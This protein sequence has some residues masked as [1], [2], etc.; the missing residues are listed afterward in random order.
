MKTKLL[1]LSMAIILSL[2]VLFANHALVNASFENFLTWTE[3]DG[4]DDVTVSQYSTQWVNELRGAE[5]YVYSD[6]GVGYLD[7]SF[8]V[9]FQAICNGAT[10]GVDAGSHW[11]VANALG[12]KTTLQDADEDY[13][14]FAHIHPSSPDEERWYLSERVGADSYN[15][16]STSYFIPTLSTTYYITIIR[17]ELTTAYGQLKAYIYSNAAMTQE[18]LVTTLSLNLHQKTDF[19]L[20]YSHQSVGAD[21]GYFSSGLT[22]YMEVTKLTS[23]QEPLVITTSAQTL[24]GKVRLSGWASIDNGALGYI[25]FQI[26][27][28]SETYTAN[29][30]AT[31]VTGSDTY[32]YADLTSSNLTVGETYYFI[33]TAN[34]TYGY[35][36]GSEHSFI[37]SFQTITITTSEAV[38]EE[39]ANGKFSAAFDFFVS[40]NNVTTAYGRMSTTANFS[41]SIDLWAYIIAVLGDGQGQYSYITYNVTDSYGLLEPETTYY[42]QGYIVF[43]GQ[44]Y[45]GKIKSFET[46]AA[47]PLPDKPIVSITSVKDVH[48]IYGGQY[49]FEF[50]ALATSSNSTDTFYTQGFDFSLY[51]NESAGVLLPTIYSYLVNKNADNTFNLVINLDNASW[52]TGQVLYIR[53]FVNT[54]RYGKVYST[55]VSFVSEEEDGDGI[56]TGGET[57]ETIVLIDDLFTQVR[58][59]LGLTGLMGAWAF[60]GLILLLIALVFG[61]V[62]VSNEQGRAVIGIIWALISIS[63]VGAFIFTGTLGLWP[64]LIMVGGVVALLLIVVSVKL[65]GS[66]A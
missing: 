45:S 26:G 43:E 29:Y 11:V 37:A 12:S 50:T 6:M 28:V 18:Y 44:T 35:G 2:T 16:S 47:L 54:L 34:N 46:T 31:Y 33:A 14:A 17:D 10:S 64:I 9:T 7:A 59:K 49:L 48:D 36:Y 62:M 56:I 55:I 66:N 23:G 15:T 61:V 42:Y 40:P 1:R 27:T 13:L 22:S 65:S 39:Q 38:I 52:Y 3:V 30:T 25:G 32:F 21:G 24:T 5:N 19:Q 8:Q 4:G 63:V 53:A 58:N 51:Q 41:D 20:I 60:M 57:D